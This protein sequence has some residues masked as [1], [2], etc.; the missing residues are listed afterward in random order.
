M[1]TVKA[2][3]GIPLAVKLSPFYSSVANVAARVVELG[4]DGLVVFNRFYQPDF[5]LDELAV[6]ST[7]TLSTS[8]DL[9]LRLRWLALLHGRVRASLAVTG[10]VH[11]PT[12]ALKAVMAG[13]SAVQVVSALLKHGPAHIKTLVDGLRTWLE[14]HEYESLSQARGSLS[15]DRSPNPAAF[16]RAQYMRLLQT[17]KM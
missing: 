3:V 4:A 6:E 7:L 2:A 17:F 15:L 14:Q 1:K 10:G 13:A 9:L 16:E 8:A 5:N 12:D 11:A